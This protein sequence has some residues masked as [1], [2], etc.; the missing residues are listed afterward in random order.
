MDPTCK[1]DEKSCKTIAVSK[2]DTS[3]ECHSG[4]LFY[5]IYSDKWGRS[6]DDMRYADSVLEV[7]KAIDVLYRTREAKLVR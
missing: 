6:R 2:N 3:P 7:V 4:S 1:G 5:N